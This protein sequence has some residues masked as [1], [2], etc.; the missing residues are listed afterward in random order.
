MDRS[1][2]LALVLELERSLSILA[3]ALTEN[4][5]ILVQEGLANIQVEMAKLREMLEEPP[6][7]S[8]NT[9]KP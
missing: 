1:Q 2:V 3:L 4:N 7:D 5:D 6:S 8:S 9:F